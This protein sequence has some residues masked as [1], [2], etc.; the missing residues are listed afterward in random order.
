[1]QS[2]QLNSVA[3]LSNAVSVFYSSTTAT[4]ASIRMVLKSEIKSQPVE[5][6][7]LQLLCS[8]I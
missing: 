1:M 8:I 5:P 3:I 4:L 6:Y 7:T 2:S